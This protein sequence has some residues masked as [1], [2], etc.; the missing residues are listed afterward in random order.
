M[1]KGDEINKTDEGQSDVAPTIETK[2]S[3][4]KQEQKYFTIEALK[5]EFEIR[6]SVFAAIKVSKSWAEGKQVSKEEFKV[7][8]EDWLESPIIKESKR[9]EGK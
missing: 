1:A 4:L 8:V 3:L 7:A 2:N 9:K 5:D 6:D